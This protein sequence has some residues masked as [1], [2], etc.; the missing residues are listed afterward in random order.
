MKLFTVI[1]IDFLAMV[2]LYINGCYIVKFNENQYIYDSSIILIDLDFHNGNYIM[3]AI[4]KFS[5]NTS[6][7]LML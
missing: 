6:V 7:L 5:S 3:I 1:Q 2:I 4:I